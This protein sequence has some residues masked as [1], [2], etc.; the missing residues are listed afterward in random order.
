MNNSFSQQDLV[1]QQ[2]RDIRLNVQKVAS[3][4]V[5]SGQG[6]N[7]ASVTEYQ[8]EKQISFGLIDYENLGKLDNQNAR[9]KKMELVEDGI[10]KLTTPIK[11]NFRKDMN[12]QHDPNSSI[13]EEQKLNLKMSHDSQLSKSLIYDDDNLELLNSEHPQNENSYKRLYVQKSSEFEQEQPKK[14]RTNLLFELENVQKLKNS[15]IN[16]GEAFQASEIKSAIDCSRNK[17]F[18]S[19]QIRQKQLLEALSN[20]NN[21]GTQNIQ[22]TQPQNPY[23]SS[24]NFPQGTQQL[25]N[26]QETTP[27]KPSMIKCNC[28]SKLLCCLKLYNN[29]HPPNSE[30]KLNKVKTEIQY[31]EIGSKLDR[32]HNQKKQRTMNEI[33]QMNSLPFE[34]L[35]QL[36]LPRQSIDQT[37]QSDLLPP[38]S[39][40]SKQNSVIF[41]TSTEKVNP[42]IFPSISV[43]DQKSEQFGKAVEN[44]NPP[45]LQLSLSD[46][47]NFKTPSEDSANVQPTQNKQG[48]VASEIQDQVPVLVVDDSYSPIITKDIYPAAFN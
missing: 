40:I 37:P 3:F 15:T 8:Q 33:K 28:C 26:K 31:K 25:Q 11:K 27:L 23:H 48:T 5:S 30:S 32:P 43:D 34:K 2:Q 18:S 19:S 38:H 21:T 44:L 12:R 39:S 14:P 35:E 29:V 42:K 16:N 46:S 9:T 20:E 17:D 24:Q 41:K 7:P 4:V 36:Q 10:D 22:Q 13:K 1:E 45:N 6:L 47:V